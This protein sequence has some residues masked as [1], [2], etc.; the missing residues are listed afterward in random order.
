MRGGDGVPNHVGRLRNTHTRGSRRGLPILWCSVLYASRVVSTDLADR[1][2]VA[3][4]DGTS[5]GTQENRTMVVC[6]CYHSN[7]VC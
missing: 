7:A 1:A 2:L 4:D 5:L 3:P 6:W